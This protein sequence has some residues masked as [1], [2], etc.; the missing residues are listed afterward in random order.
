MSE[1]TLTGKAELEQIY[2]SL[3]KINDH[4][5]DAMNEIGTLGKRTEENLD[6]TT[7][8][9]ENNIKK[10][11]G[12]LRRLAS[13]LFSDFKALASLQSV[14]AGLKLSSQ[15]SGSLKESVKLND[16]VRRLGTSFGVAKKDFGTFQAA[17]ARGL[18]DIGASSE[19]ASNALEG[20]AGF[21][22]EG[23]ESAKNLAKGAVTLA[24]I[25]GEKGNEKQVASGIASAIQNQGKD[26][27]DLGAQKA[28]IGEVTAAVTATGKSASEILNAMNEIF[29]SMPVELRKSIGPAAMAQMATIATTVG[30]SATK[31]IQ[32]YLS[33]STEQRTAME[34]QGFNVFKGGKLDMNALKSFIK[35]TEG[36]GLS[37]RES[38]KSAG[39]SDEAAEG[40]VRIGEKSDLVSKNLEKLSG[41]TRDNEAAFRSTMGI[42]DSFKGSINTVKGWAESAFSGV[43]QTIN[44]ILSRQVGHAGAAAVVAGGGIAAAALTGF[45]VK[46]ISEMLLG[47]TVGGAVSHGLAEETLGADVQKVF[48]VNAAEISGGGGGVKSAKDILGGAKSFIPAL[49]AFGLAA[50]AVGAAG[51]TYALAGYGAGKFLVNPALDK[52]TQGE[53]ESGFQ[54]NAVERL[55]DKLDQWTGGSLSGNQ[56]PEVTVKIETKE[57]NL[58]PRSGPT[59][60]TSN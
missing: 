43:S 27:N 57:P 41:A 48:V 9:T 11:G 58:M 4:A 17:L 54:G 31:A 39:F 16:T 12:L 20:M 40:L 1:V 22:V 28:V 14:A 56:P 18:G 19:A 50:G 30:P 52:L 29:T 15:F 24:G 13:Q 44:D 49:G 21:G 51:A 55:L 53:N 34:A 25:G 36:R 46:K 37:A 26:V 59:R 3:K 42:M 47:K 35:T 6:K 32:E 60:G 38:L 5:T 23:I 45:G 2:K 8:K 33:K 7:K 10:T